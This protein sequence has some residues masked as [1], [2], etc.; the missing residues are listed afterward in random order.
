MDIQQWA[1]DYD[2]IM[3]K[4]DGGEWAKYDDVDILN[5]EAERWRKVLSDIEQ[6]SADNMDD[7]AT[8]HA[9][10]K[11]ASDALRGR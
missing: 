1:Q 11:L 2:H 7:R 8:V 3:I 6:R 4:Q 5:Q 10:H 9:V